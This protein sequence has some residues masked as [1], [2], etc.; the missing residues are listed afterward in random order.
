MTMIQCMS[1][2][3]DVKLHFGTN[4]I[5]PLS[6]HNSASVMSAVCRLHCAKTN[7]FDIIP[8]SL[9]RC[10]LELLE[11]YKIQIQALITFECNFKQISVFFGFYMTVASNFW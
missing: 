3:Q 8:A 7:C 6:G 9:R 1:S 2:M 4:S 5:I 11:K 10:L